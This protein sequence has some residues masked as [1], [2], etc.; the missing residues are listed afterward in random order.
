MSNSSHFLSFNAGQWWLGILSFDVGCFL[1]AGFVVTLSLPMGVDVSVSQ[2][3]GNSRTSLA[4][5]LLSSL[6][7]GTTLCLVDLH[8]SLRFTNF[9]TVTN[10]ST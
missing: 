6:K 2:D 5:M 8:S 10:N 9:P 7:I 3:A 1:L 4:L